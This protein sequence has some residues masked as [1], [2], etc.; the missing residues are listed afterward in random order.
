MQL[1]ILNRTL[2]Y[3]PTDKPMRV[4]GFMSG[5]GSNL[6]KIIEHQQCTS[7]YEV[8]V[9]FTDNPHSAAKTIGKEFG[10]PV[11]TH[12]IKQFY[13][14][15][16]ASLTDLSLRPDFDRAT[17]HALE[18]YTV[19]VAAYA[20]YMSIASGVLVRAFL[21]INVHPAD[22][23][24]IENGK[25]KYTGA[26][27]V[28]D[29]VLARETEMRSTTHLVETQVDGGRILMV[30][31]PVTIPVGTGLDTSLPREVQNKIVSEYQN[32]LKQIGDWD[33]FPKTLEYLATGRFAQDDRGNLYFDNNPI[34]A[35]VRLC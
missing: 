1:N 26:H 35:G 30:S 22:L 7:A 19:A 32:K 25:R 23:S 4:A 17:I 28:R 15:H 13:Q 6:R 31:K 34:P 12:N 18:P 29:A 27:C 14:E 9:I 33:I 10:I 20:G 3:T 5:H 11:I 16:T 8:V 24:I 2:L 21:G